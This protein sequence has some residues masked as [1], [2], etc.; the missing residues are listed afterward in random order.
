MS[1]PEQWLQ[2]ARSYLE[3]DPEKAKRIFSKIVSQYPDSSAAFSAQLRLRRM[4]DDLL[5]LDRRGKDAPHTPHARSLM[6]RV[7][8]EATAPGRW[9]VLAM[10]LFIVAV[11]ADRAWL[12][13]KSQIPY[14]SRVSQ[15]RSI[16]SDAVAL[17][18]DGQVQA[19][20]RRYST[21]CEGSYGIDRNDIPAGA[22]EGAYRLSASLRTAY[23][24]TIAALER[25]RE[26]T[27]RYPESLD[28]IAKEIPESSV[29]AFSG[30]RYFRNSDIDVDIVTGRYGSV[31]FDLSGR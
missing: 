25:Y 7:L 30:F 21:I 8:K 27:G 28:A 12:A 23:E 3:T 1:V 31:T 24:H 4:E 16:F 5:A 6:T 9:F 19:A 26:A 20:Y 10:L 13:R 22:C 29:A 17:E 18:R 14:E 2:A 15:V 11:A